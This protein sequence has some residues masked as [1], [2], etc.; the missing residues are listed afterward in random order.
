VSAAN[1]DDVVDQLRAAGL[2]F[3]YLTTG[4]MVRCKVD[5]EREKRGWYALHELQTDGGDLLIVGSYGVWRGNDNGAT[6]IELRKREISAE[7]RDSLRRR[8]AEDRKRADL[9][10]KGEQE[11]AAQAAAKAWAKCAASGDCDYLARKGVGAHGVR[12]TA[13]GAMVIPVL[14]VGGKVHALQ[15][16]RSAAEAKKRDKLQKEFWPRGAAKKGHFHLIGIPQHVV[17]VVEGYATGATVHEA[18]GLPVAIAFD[19]GNIAPVAAALRKRYK[20]ARILI[21]A[22][23]DTFAKCGPCRERG[24]STRVILAEDPTTCPECGEPHRAGNAGVAAASGAALEVSGAWF[25]P[26]F[27]DEDGRRERYLRAGA[28]ESDFNDLAVREGLHVVRAQVEARLSELGWSA[29]GRR[30]PRAGDTGGEGESVLRPIEDLDELLE[31]FALVYGQS[32]TVFDRQEHCLLPL[33]DMRDACLTRDLHRAWAE[34]P[35][36]VI[37]RVREVGFDPACSDPLVTCNLWAGWPTEPKPGNCE[38]LLELLRHMCSAERHSDRLYS[39]VLRWIAYPIQHPGAK[40]KTTLVLHGPQGTGKNMFFEALMAIYGHYG[41][42]IDQSAIEDRFNDWASRKLFLIADEVVARADLFHVKNKLKAFITG[43]WIRINPK[44]MAAYDERN[45][46][47]VVFLSNEAMPVVLEEDDRRHTVIWTPDK[48]P[49]EFY[50]DVKAEIAA[51]GIAA[52]HDHLLH[53]DLGDFDEATMPPFTDAKAELI[54]LALDSPSRFYYELTTGDVGGIRARPALAND[55]YELYKA[56]CHKAGL[57]AAP[58]N[59]FVNALERK[60]QTP[61]L[62]KRYLSGSD[63][64]GP[65]G[66]FVALGG[67]EMPP[68]AVESTWLGEMIEGF[69]SAVKDYRGSAYA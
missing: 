30:A 56:W 12:F 53:L 43:D 14:D 24:V 11:R 18:T 58:Q 13:S 3:D 22:D 52:L 41:R 44:N 7:Q 40:M 51:G 67:V 6:K 59:K 46:V 29:A 49:P 20:Q 55:V 16:I 19:A 68:E 25:A 2:L 26:R 10:R 36:R 50:R 32:G 65:H 23:D 33:S 9:I 69:R 47:N 27:A 48:L 61:S 31:R 8:L 4:C 57:R 15:I 62:R 66:V 35:D 54:R 38:R 5:G 39:W 63:I 34:H 21:G 45:H 60:H 1:Y 37:V 17:I 42:V 64:K 28:K